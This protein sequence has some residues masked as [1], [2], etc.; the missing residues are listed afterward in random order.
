MRNLRRKNNFGKIIIFFFLITLSLLTYIFLKSN[1]F[2]IKFIE[3]KKENADCLN[4]EKVKSESLGQNILLINEGNIAQQIKKNFICVKSISFSKT[5]P[6]KL[7]IN[8]SGRIPIALLISANFEA[9]ASSLIENI[10]TPSATD[11]TYLLDDEGVV[12]A[13][14][15]LDIPKIY[16][17]GRDI[18]LGNEDDYLKKSLKI[19]DTLKDLNIDNKQNNIFNNLF[20]TNSIPKVI[21]KLD[22]SLDTQIA[23]LQ[24]ILRMAKIGNNEL[25]FIDLRFDKPVLKFAPRKN[26]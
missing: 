25:E 26:G 4:K 18:N 3:V 7:R 10:A 22:D 6:D 5:L 16:L 17:I 24:L 20:I 15:S 13:K 21:F 1:I 9:S 11:R 12:Y 2:S 14:G 23:S 8:I 19:I